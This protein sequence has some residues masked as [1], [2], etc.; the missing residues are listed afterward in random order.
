MRRTCLVK[1]GTRL[2]AEL[3]QKIR[4]GQS[5]KWHRTSTHIYINKQTSPIFN[6][7]TPPES[8]SFAPLLPITLLSHKVSTSTIEWNDLIW[9]KQITDRTSLDRALYWLCRNQFQFTRFFLLCG[10]GH[11]QLRNIIVSLYFTFRDYSNFP[12]EFRLWWI[13]SKW[14]ALW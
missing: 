6:C 10:C 14:P 13:E 8:V 1:F 7:V 9:S 2:K 12:Y 11:V 4:K 5:T 3:T